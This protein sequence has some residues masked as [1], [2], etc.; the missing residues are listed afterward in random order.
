VHEELLAPARVRGQLSSDALPHR[1]PR[2]ERQRDCRTRQKDGEKASKAKG[3]K[4]KTYDAT[5]D[6]TRRPDSD[7]DA[8]LEADELFKEMKRREF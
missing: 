7:S 6:A 4:R 2:H 5:L 3:K 8:D 1:S